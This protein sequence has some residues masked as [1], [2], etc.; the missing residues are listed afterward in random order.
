MKSLWRFALVALLSLCIGAG[1]NEA[2]HA[3]RNRRSKSKSP[4]GG[5]LFQHRLRCKTVAD[6]YIR[7]NSD[8]SSALFLERVDYSPSRHSCIAALIRWTTGK[9]KV[10]TCNCF[11]EIHDY[12]TVD[13]LSGESLYSGECL[14]NDPQS[15][16]FCGG[17][18]D[19][20]L[21]EERGKALDSSLASNE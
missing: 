9:R 16:L 8:D 20:R 7:A 1:L 21:N 10:Q 17:G 13:L 11:V 6:D 19:M 5:E 12:Q 3:V 18:R 4:E 14:E 2:L 15:T